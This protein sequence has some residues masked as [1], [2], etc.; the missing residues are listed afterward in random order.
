LAGGDDRAGR[1]TTPHDRRE[2]AIHGMTCASCAGRME[3]ALSLV[4]GVV[5]A[6]I[7][8]AAEKATVEGVALS[9]AALIGAVQD[10]GYNADLLP[11]MR[12]SGASWKRRK[13]GVYAATCSVWQV[14]RCSRR[15]FS[16]RW[17]G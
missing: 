12:N 6:E 13:A 16:C 4:A 8:L 7:N 14:R 5:R 10:A 11:A 2:L 17:R 3:R 1:Y 15:P 9:P